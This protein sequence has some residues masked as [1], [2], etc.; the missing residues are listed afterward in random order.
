MNDEWGRFFLRYKFYFNG[1]MVLLFTRLFYFFYF[2][3]EIRF[4]NRRFFRIY[5]YVGKKYKV[6]FDWFGVMFRILDCS[7]LLYIIN[8]DIIWIVIIWN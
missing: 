6:V 5:F 2:G 7:F 8:W 4:V 1:L 3:R